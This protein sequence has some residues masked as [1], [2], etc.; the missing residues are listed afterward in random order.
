MKNVIEN[1]SYIPYGRKISYLPRLL[2]IQQSISKST[3]AANQIIRFNEG[4]EIE[5]KRG[6]QINYRIVSGFFL[7]EKYQFY[8]HCIALQ[9]ISINKSLFSSPISQHFVLFSSF[10]NRHSGFCSKCDLHLHR[11][12][13]YVCLYGFYKY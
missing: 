10:N 11:I 13:F 6:H 8:I 2:T 5:K 12:D 9:F 1:E 7:L 3:L 4:K